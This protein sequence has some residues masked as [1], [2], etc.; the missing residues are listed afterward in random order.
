MNAYLNFP[1][2]RTVA[3]SAGFA[4]IRWTQPVVVEKAGLFLP[5]APELSVFGPVAPCFIVRTF[6]KRPL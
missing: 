5:V 2:A 6:A 1:N 3:V 4:S